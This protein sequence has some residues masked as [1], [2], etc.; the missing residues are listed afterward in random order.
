MIPVDTSLKAALEENPRWAQ[1]L[2]TLTRTQHHFPVLGTEDLGSMY[3]FQSQDA[4]VIL[5]RSFTREEYTLGA[6]VCLISEALALQAGIGPGDTL[7]LS[8]FLIEERR[9]ESLS[10]SFD[11]ML[12]NPT[13]GKLRETYSYQTQ[14][15]AYTVVGIYRQNNLWEESSCSVTPNTVFIPKKAQIPGGYGEPSRILE[16][17]FM[18]PDGQDIQYKEAVERG[19]YGVY[20]SM[21]LRNGMAEDF[22]LAIA[23]TPWVGEF[24]VF[25]Q[26]YGAVMRSM[27]GTA[28]SAKS[29]LLTACAGW[30]AV[31]ALYVLLCQNGQRKN[32]G[33]MCSLGTGKKRARRYL[34]AGGLLLAAAGIAVGTGLTAAVSGRIGDRLLLQMLQQA[35]KTQN[36]VGV[37]VTQE[38]LAGLIVQSQLPVWALVLLGILQLAVFALALWVH[39]A[40]LTRRSPRKLMGV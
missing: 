6:K 37:G 9:N 7:H 27:E 4:S 22:A 18:G 16:G 10:S 21:V 28:E 39:A 26:G 17:S 23:E 31:L 25:D 34:F 33:I 19:C 32:I 14:D 2:D 38:A 20:F 35:E 29:L 11:G 8:Q 36:S 5:G 30:A 3:L 13:V 24:Q 15:E 12:N 1:L 40:L